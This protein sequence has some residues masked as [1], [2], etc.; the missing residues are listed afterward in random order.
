MEEQG[1]RK[2]RKYRRRTD[3]ERIAELQSKIAAIQ[4]KQELKE[5][6]DSPVIKEIPRIQRRLNKFAQMALDHGREDLANSTR[7][8]VAGLDRVLTGETATRRRER[9]PKGE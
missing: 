8:F 9:R 6:K 7:A 1:T 5:R 3:E 4:K 2:K